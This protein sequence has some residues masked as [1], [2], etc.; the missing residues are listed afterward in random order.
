[1]I[2]ILFGL[3]AILA[4]IF[5]LLVIVSLAMIFINSKNHDCFLEFKPIGLKFKITYR[6]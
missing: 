4:L 5:V 6:K 2:N 3:V 1:M